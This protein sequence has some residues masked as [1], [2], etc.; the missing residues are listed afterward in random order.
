MGVLLEDL[1]NSIQTYLPYNEQ[2][3]RDKEII[4]TCFDH[5]DDI[6]TRENKIAHMTS[7]AFVVNKNRNKTLMVYHNI[8]H[9]WSWIGGHADGEKD[10]LSVAI[11]EAKEE[12]GIQEVFPINRKIWTL[13]I[14]PVLAHRK[15]GE[16]ISPHLHLSVGFLLEG[17]EKD[18]LKVKPDENSA[19]KWIPIND[20]KHYSNEDHMKKI[21]Y[22]IIKKLR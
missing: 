6:L 4:L 13:D 9:S 8:F 12:T 7:S 11:K 1:K 19:V 21:Y 10:L 14:L 16:Y 18:V 5:F 15:N 20:I 22:K 3:K 17:N 2:E